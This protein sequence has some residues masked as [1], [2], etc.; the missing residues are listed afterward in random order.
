[1]TL[2][3]SVAL[4]IAAGPAHGQAAADPKAPA[5]GTEIQEVVVTATKVGSQTVMQ[6]P[7]AIQAF[8]GESL[9]TKGI[10][11]AE[12]LISLIPGASAFGEI[13]AG[14]KVYAIRGSGRAAPSATA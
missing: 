7:M 13:S 4:G 11:E 5:A 9:E 8:S 2:V 6:T 10:H 3:A 1:M 12:D 14:Y